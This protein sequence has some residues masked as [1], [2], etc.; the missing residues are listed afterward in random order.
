MWERHVEI[1]PGTGKC[2]TRTTYGDAATFA[3]PPR[4]KIEPIDSTE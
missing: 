3:T 2:D 4:G 1:R